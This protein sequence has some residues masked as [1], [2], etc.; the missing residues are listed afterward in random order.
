M[1]S[2]NILGLYGIKSMPDGEL[3]RLWI[4][5]AIIPGRDS[6]T[7]LMQQ[8]FDFDPARVAGEDT[9]AN[10]YTAPDPFQL[11]FVAVSKGLVILNA[12]RMGDRWHKHVSGFLYNERDQEW[13]LY[14]FA[15]DMKDLSFIVRTNRGAEVGNPF[16]CI[17]LQR[18][19]N[20]AK[21]TFSFDENGFQFF[22]PLQRSHP[23]P[24]G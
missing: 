10:R 6:S 18:F 7:W 12:S 17:L 19:I 24:A 14:P 16:R 4:H 15:P 11:E 13:D 9:L 20:Y 3:A 21:G 5:E 2:E 23:P 8:L 1:L 22:H